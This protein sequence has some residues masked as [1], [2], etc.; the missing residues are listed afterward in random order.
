[1]YVCSK[2]IEK[3]KQDDGLDDL[4][5]MLDRMKNMATDMGT[6]IDRL[7]F[8]LNITIFAHCLILSR[9]KPVVF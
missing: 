6:E 2:Q 8:L 3:T 1:M 7:A 4:S 5:N 9:L